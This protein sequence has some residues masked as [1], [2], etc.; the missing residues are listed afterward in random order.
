M[1]IDFPTCVWGT[2]IKKELLNGIRFDTDIYVSEDTL[3]IAKV[4]RNTDK[5]VILHKNLYHYFQYSGSSFHGAYN[6]KRRTEFIAQRRIMRLFKDVPNV[7]INC[8]AFYADKCLKVVRRYYFNMGVSE[9]FYKKMLAEYRR[10]IKYILIR[11][12]KKKNIRDIVM[13]F[14]YLIFAIIPISYPLYYK[15]RYH[16]EE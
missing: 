11:A 16:V 1:D 14:A 3:F 4:I 9:C 10:N 5:T 7:Y 8:R 12:V 15:M 2:M 6:K 13:W